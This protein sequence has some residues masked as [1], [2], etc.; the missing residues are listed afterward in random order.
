MSSPHSLQEPFSFISIQAVL[1]STTFP[2]GYWSEM[3]TSSTQSRAW[4]WGTPGTRS[5]DSSDSFPHHLWL[6]P[7]REENLLQMTI[8]KCIFFLCCSLTKPLRFH[9]FNSWKSSWAINIQTGK[10]PRV[11]SGFAPVPQC[12]GNVKG[13]F[14]P[15]RNGAAHTNLY[16]IFHFIGHF[17]YNLLWLC[18]LFWIYI[19]IPSLEFKYSSLWVP[20]EPWAF[21]TTWHWHTKHLRLFLS[22]IIH[23]LP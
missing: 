9:E 7:Q 13:L 16:L 8:G 1:G 20:P 5:S 6:L 17:C 2:G 11:G 21:N 22:G 10:W 19:E 4:P 14:L 15:L 23:F 12:Q 3:N 18:Q